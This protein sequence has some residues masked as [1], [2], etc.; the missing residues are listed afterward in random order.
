MC[1]G[2]TAKEKEELTIELLLLLMR[3]SKREK[4]REKERQTDME[5]ERDRVRERVS[6]KET[7][8]CRNP[9]G[10]KWQKKKAALQSLLFATIQM[11]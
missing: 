11:K 4:E 2:R 8:T 6:E 10:A 7:N 9:G 1:D 5:G 3:E